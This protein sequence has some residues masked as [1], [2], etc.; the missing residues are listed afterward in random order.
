MGY[1]GCTY[2]SQARAHTTR[3]SDGTTTRTTWRHP[4]R[5]MASLD[6]VDEFLPGR[7]QGRRRAAPE[8]ECARGGGTA[9]QLRQRLNDDQRVAVGIA[10]P[11]QRRDRATD[12]RDLVVDVDAGGLQG[13]V[14]GVHVRRVE[15]DAG[16]AAARLLALRRGARAIVVFVRAARPRPSASRAP[17]G[18]RRPSRSR[19]CRRRS[20]SPGRCPR[21]SRTRGRPRRCS[22]WSPLRTSEP[23]ARGFTGSTMRPTDSHRCARL[24][25]P[26]KRRQPT[27]PWPPSSGSWAR[28]WTGTWTRPAA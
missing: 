23:P 27:P 14:V 13:R 2:R 5:P 28:W 1:P 7:R 8:R 20:R 16:L 12:A 18:R 17:S 21:R 3:A 6:K 15:A 24:R 11:E 9:V 4:L 25:R 26:M 22:A 10:Q 19:A